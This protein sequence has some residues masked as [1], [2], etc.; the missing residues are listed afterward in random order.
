[1]T[2]ASSV[3]DTGTL[4][5]ILDKWLSTKGLFI[6]AADAARVEFVGVHKVVRLRCASEIKLL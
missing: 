2:D 3:S 1:M 4:T 5:L 6:S